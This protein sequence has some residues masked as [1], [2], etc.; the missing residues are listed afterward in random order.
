MLCIS[1]A[2][3]LTWGRA[4]ASAFHTINFN[5][6]FE[7]KQICC[8]Q[9]GK[10]HPVNY[11]HVKFIALR[12][13]VVALASAFAQ[14]KQNMVQQLVNSNGRRLLFHRRRRRRVN[15]QSTRAKFRLRA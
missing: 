5:V 14:K 4:R 10:N 15:M 11:H 8:A 12:S 7:R 13:L 3:L 2:C 1:R 9:K 6:C